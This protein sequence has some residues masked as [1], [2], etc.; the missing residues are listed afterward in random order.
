MRCKTQCLSV[1]TVVPGSVVKLKGEFLDFT[2]HVV[3]R[4]AAGPLPADLTYR[5]ALRVRAVVPEGA[6]ASRPYVTDEGGVKS[7]RA[8]QKLKVSAASALPSYLFPVKGAHSYGDGFGAP[9]GGRTHQGQ[10]LPAAC[11]RPL[12]ASAAA[13]VTYSGYQAS[14]GNYLVLSVAGSDLDLVYMHML[15]TPLV[16]SKQTVAAGQLVGKV[17]NTGHSFGCHLHF[18]IWQGGWYSGGSPIDPLPYLKQ[19]DAS[20]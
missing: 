16:K 7:N 11:G 19:W 18:E 4:G 13:T 9:R 20:S 8:P 6:I 3:F 1:R 15:E 12:V 10:D 2:Q 14:T 5:D 17:G